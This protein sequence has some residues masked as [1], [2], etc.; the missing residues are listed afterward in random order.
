MQ[1][2]YTA[3]YHDEGDAETKGG[4]E[5]NSHTKIVAHLVCLA[6]NLVL[7]VRSVHVN[8][9]QRPVL[10]TSSN[11]SPLTVIHSGCASELQRSG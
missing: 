2:E 8:E 7:G 9:M 4:T 11:P 1:P 3:K 6:N 5:D 10:S